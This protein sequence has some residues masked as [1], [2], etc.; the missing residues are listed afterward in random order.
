MMITN[1][2]VKG[3][4]SSMPIGIGIGTA[5][6]AIATGILA[7][8]LTW[9]VLKR[10]ISETSIGYFVLG[11]IL[12]SSVVGSL[13][14]AVKI[15]RRWMFVCCLTGVMYYLILLASTA[16]FFGGNYR[17]IGVTG[18]AVLVGA[19]TAGLGGLKKE[20][21]HRKRFSKYQTR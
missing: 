20:G 21:G 14:A 5:V 17:G 7:T 2:R 3:T 13:V 6:S 15:K 18:L 9:L 16:V 11:I 12:L 19:L 10:K 1:N 8:A 4:A